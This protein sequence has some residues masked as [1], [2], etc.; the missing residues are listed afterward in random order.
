MK[1]GYVKRETQK[2]DKNSNYSFPNVMWRNFFFL[3]LKMAE[4][5]KYAKCPTIKNKCIFDSNFNGKAPGIK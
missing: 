2:V 1:N 4:L 5:V 3:F